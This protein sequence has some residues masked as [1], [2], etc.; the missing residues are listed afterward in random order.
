MPI[1]FGSN[2]VFTM[3]YSSQ[4]PPARTRPSNCGSRIADCGLGTCPQGIA[5]WGQGL[6][7]ACHGVAEGE[8]G[9]QPQRGR[10]VAKARKTRSL[11]MRRQ[12]P[13][14]SGRTPRFGSPTPCIFVGSEL[15]RNPSVPDTFGGVWKASS[16]AE[17]KRRGHPGAPGL[18][19]ALQR[20]SRFPNGSAGQGDSAG[21]VGARP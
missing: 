19:A 21:P 10:F 5:D 3:A 2:P 9:A 15:R 17:Q 7:I 18:I 6:G 12:I 1:L 11:W 8:A 13:T 4:A 16:A 20:L 14:Q